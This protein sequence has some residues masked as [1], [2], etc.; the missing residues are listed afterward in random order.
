[1]SKQN[2]YIEELKKVDTSA[3]MIEHNKEFNY[4]IRIL[5][6]GEE[7]FYFDKAKDK[8]LIIDIQVR[9]GSI[10]SKSISK[11]SDG[12]EILEID[13]DIIIERLINYFQEFQKIKAFVR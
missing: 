7:L 3:P 2:S 8:A 5:H 4:V 11:W 13:K 1:M 10:F 12:E 9:N 6:K